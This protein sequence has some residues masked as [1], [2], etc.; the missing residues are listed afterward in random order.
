MKRQNSIDFD[1][2]YFMDIEN[3]ATKRIISL[4]SAGSLPA[5]G[6]TEDR[7]PEKA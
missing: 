4:K 1:Q 2:I 3:S 6:R 5:I 7:R